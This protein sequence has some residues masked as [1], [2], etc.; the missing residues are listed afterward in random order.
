M[1]RWIALKPIWLTRGIV[2]NMV[3]I[4][5]IH[6]LQWP[7]FPLFACFLVAAMRSCPLFQLE[8]KNVFLHGDITEEV[9]ME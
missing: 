3:Q 6:F 1:V 5:I 7:R 9:Y 2:S 4:I 8:I